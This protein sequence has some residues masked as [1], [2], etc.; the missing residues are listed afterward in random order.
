[1]YC[2]GRTLMDLR[3]MMGDGSGASGG[4]SIQLD[5]LNAAATAERKRKRAKVPGGDD[6][7]ERLANRLPRQELLERAGRP[8]R[9][10]A[11]GGVVVRCGVVLRPGVGR[12]QSQHA[13]TSAV[14]PLLPRSVSQSQSA[15]VTW[16]HM[17]SLFLAATVRCDWAAA[18]ERD[19]LAVRRTR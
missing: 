7:T 5:K 12:A 1:M 13:S 14:N 17:E 9:A 3:E 19:M 15:V 10:T 6:G 2:V 11:A 4:G 18:V 16:L 8:D